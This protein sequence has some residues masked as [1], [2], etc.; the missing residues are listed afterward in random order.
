MKKETER[1]AK[2]F[3]GLD[4]AYGAV[5][6]APG[7]NGTKQQGRYKFVQEERTLETFEAHLE[8]KTSIGIVPINE[9][10]KC[11][12]GAIDIDTYPLDHTAIVKKIEKLKFPL[13]LCRSKSGGGHIYL[14]MKNFV[15]AE[16]IQSKSLQPNW[17]MPPTPKFFPSK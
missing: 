11:I 8:G 15:P 9:D 7:P 14:F 13:V 17:V 4:K 10:N 2:L 1:F 5:D 12:W 16:K 3:R 6:I